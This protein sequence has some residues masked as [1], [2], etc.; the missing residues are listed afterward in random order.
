VKAASE[1]Y[2]PLTGTVTEANVALVDDPALV[3]RSPE[4][5]GWFFRLR[6][7]DPSEL[8]GLMDQAAYEQLVA[9]L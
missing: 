7:S 8:E 5:E 2:A 6:L 1:I 4:G 9:S 3:N